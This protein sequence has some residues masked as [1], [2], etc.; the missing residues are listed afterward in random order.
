MFSFNL[1]HFAD[2]GAG[3]FKEMK[4]YPNLPCYTGKGIFWKIAF[5]TILWPFYFCMF[6]L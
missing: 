4:N 6:L 1:D 5:P 2:T 3:K